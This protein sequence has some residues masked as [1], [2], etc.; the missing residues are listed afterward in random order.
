MA[1][2]PGYEVV[3][4]QTSMAEA[5]AG[6]QSACF[7]T[8]S[9]AQRMSA[10]HYRS[11]MAVFPEG[12][13][14]VVEMATGQVVAASTDFRTRVDFGHFQHRY[15]E[16]VADNWLTSHDPAGDWLYGA[17][18]GVHPG[19]RG[20]GLSTALYQAQQALVRR[21]GLRGHVVGALP[22]GYGALA[23]EVAIEA[24]VGS[25]V[26]GARTDPPLTV[27]LRRGYEVYG[28]IPGYVDDPACAGYGVFLVW[29]NPDRALDE[30]TSAGGR[31]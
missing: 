19:F 20:R 27:P 17:D 12:Q 14:A 18:V 15:M 31:P 29:R 7:P 2:A 26:R 3:R 28:I 10:E 6:I 1:T 23:R 25:V 9:P 30:A 22:G 8:L 4:S 5:L 21:L 24:Y 11:H 13:H 16:A